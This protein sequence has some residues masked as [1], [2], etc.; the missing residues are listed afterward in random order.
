MAAE[1]YANKQPAR[2]LALQSSQTCKLILT[3]MT[4]C[5]IISLGPLIKHGMMWYLAH[6][7]QTDLETQFLDN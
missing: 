7:F 4:I 2:L 6:G 3:K 1:H 5:L